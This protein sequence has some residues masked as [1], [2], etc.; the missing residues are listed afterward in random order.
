MG[1]KEKTVKRVV[2][3]TNVLISAILFKGA[4][5]RTVDSWTSGKIVPVLSRETFEE[6][7]GALRYPKFELTEDEIKLIIEEEV[8][9]FFDIVEIAGDINELCRDHDEDKFI[10][11]AL[12]SSADFIVSGDRDLLDM[13]AYRAIKIISVSDLLRII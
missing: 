8:L 9:P 3:D 7:R 6:F 11:C 1:A 13:K 5:A 4:R 12:S 10:A 2:L